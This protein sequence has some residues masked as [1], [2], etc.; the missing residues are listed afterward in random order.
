MNERTTVKVILEGDAALVDA[1]VARLREMFTVTYESKNVQHIRN[2]HDD[3]RRHLRLL[4][5]GL[6]HIGE[7]R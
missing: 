7:E 4:P 1:I 3:V 5:P 6:A 2:A